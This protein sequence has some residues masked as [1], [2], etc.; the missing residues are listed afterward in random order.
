MKR[1]LNYCKNILLTTAIPIV[2]F[3]LSLALFPSRINLGLLP[4]LLM[5]AI[6]PA[7]LAWGV[8]FEIKVGLWDFSVGAVILIS[9]IVG[10]SLAGML[11]LGVIGIVILCP[12]IGLMIGLMTGIV[13]TVL[14]IPSIIV[15]IGI[16]LVLESISGLIFNG[17]GVLV[18]DDVFK[19]AEFPLNIV[20]G[21]VAFAIAYFMY[22]FRRL[23][24][25][26]R[27]VGNGITV[28]KLNGININRVRILCFA[29]TGLFAGIFAFMQL[30]GSGVM[31]AQSNMTTM[32]VVVDAIIC[33]CIAL[34]LEKVSN[35]IVGVYIGSITTQIIKIAI[36]VSGFPSMY[37]QVII[38]IFLLIFM[39]ISSR[40]DLIH[41]VINRW[42]GAVKA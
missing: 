39:G 20:I 13:F 42:K 24:Y 32:G 26:V 21:L 36:L 22:N 1:F 4:V 25:H 31:K 33:A 30:G 35:L 37:Q 40:S 17:Q 27:A 7:I 16:M 15:S 18:S 14:K 3:L 23:G 34:S 2:L 19:L 6:P 12:M 10:G 8:C 38:A 28:A 41:N 29:M 9:G 11:H 5:Q